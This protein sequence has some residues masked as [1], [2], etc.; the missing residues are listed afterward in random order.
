MA[1]REGFFERE[2]FER[3]LSHL[4]EHLV[5]IAWLAYYTGMRRGEILGLSWRS[6]DRTAMVI[7]LNVTKNGR[8]RVLAYGKMPELVEVIERQ[9]ETRTAV[10]RAGGAVTPWVFHVSGAPVTPKGLYDSW[11]A[12]CA[13]AGVARLFH[14]LRRTAIRNLV[15]AGVPD[16]IAMAVSGHRTRAVFD[17]YNIVD[18]GDIADAFAALS[19]N[20]SH[21]ADKPV[22]E[23]GAGEGN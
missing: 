22:P 18:E 13:K 16:V 20:L 15:R 21:K 23:V 9:H 11:R 8:R 5:V 7:R 17:R 6:I 10:A 12:A 14:D 2:E 3:V 1:L 19:H 4:S